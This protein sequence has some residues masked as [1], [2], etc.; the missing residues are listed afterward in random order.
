M[1]VPAVWNVHTHKSLLGVVG[2]IVVI[3]VIAGGGASRTWFMPKRTRRRVPLDYLH[4]S[5]TIS[6]FHYNAGR[7]GRTGK[8]PVLDS[9]K[10]PSKRKTCILGI[11]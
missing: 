10:V 8:F 9:Q 6:A 3:V 2:V 4:L 5:V 7:E 1:A 11:I